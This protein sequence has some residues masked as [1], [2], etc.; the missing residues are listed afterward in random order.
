MRASI[1]CDITLERV[2]L[3]ADAVLPNVN[4]L[5]GPSPA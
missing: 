3:P 2:R 5:T 4:G 1:Q